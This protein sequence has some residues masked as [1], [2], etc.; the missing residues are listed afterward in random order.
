METTKEDIDALCDEIETA[1]HGSDVQRK[2]TGKETYNERTYNGK[3][4]RDSAE[5]A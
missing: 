2:A 3:I 5:R 4:R 1:F